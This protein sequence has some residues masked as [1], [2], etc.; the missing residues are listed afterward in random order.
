MIVFAVLDTNVLVSAFLKSESVPGTVVREALEGEIIPL[1]NEE[2]L[3]EYENVLKRKK[4]RIDAYE[5]NRFLKDFEK[6]AINLKGYTS[7][8]VFVDETDVVFFEVVMEA[9]DQAD[10]YLVTGNTRHFPV[11]S[12]VVTPRQMLD[13]L[14]M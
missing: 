6:R 11:R 5:V 3:E 8:E 1:I 14:S 9:R 13:N 4:F 7:E 12:Y 2:I 10:A